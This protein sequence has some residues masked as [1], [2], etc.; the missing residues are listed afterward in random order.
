MF[1][2]E[3]T[4]IIKQFTEDVVNRHMHKRKLTTVVL[5]LLLNI[6]FIEVSNDFNPATWF[7]YKTAIKT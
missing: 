6:E 4:W 1:Y 7:N 3:S 5:R 2:F